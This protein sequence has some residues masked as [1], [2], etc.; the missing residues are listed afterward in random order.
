MSPAL[1]TLKA[2]TKG[3]LLNGKAPRKTAPAPPTMTPEEAR[4]ILE[5]FADLLEK[6]QAERESMDRAEEKLRKTSS[7]NLADAF[8]SGESLPD[9]HA[10]RADFEGSKLRARVSYEAANGKLPVALTAQGIL[11]QQRAVCLAKARTRLEGELRHKLEGIGVKG[12]PRLLPDIVAATD[13]GKALLERETINLDWNT[14]A[15]MGALPLPEGARKG[16]PRTMVPMLPPWRVEPIPESHRIH[17]LE[18]RDSWS[19]RATAGAIRGG[20]KLVGDAKALEAA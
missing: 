3:R 19:P 17:G 8:L 7:G 5:A 2:F 20:L 13:Q 1:E 15:E 6:V 10:I 4:A 11:A 14:P 12:D 18:M 16:I 9:L